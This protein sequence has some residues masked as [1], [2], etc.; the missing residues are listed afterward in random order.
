MKKTHLKILEELKQVAEQL[1]DN[2]IESF[3]NKLNKAERIFVAGEGRSGLMGKAFAMRLMHAGYD[4]FVKGETITPS[5]Q[6]ND[7]L[8]EI[9]GSGNSTSLLSAAQQVKKSGATLLLVTT[10]PDSELGHLADETIRVPAATKLRRPKEPVTIQ[11]MGNQFDQSVH[12]L[13]DAVVISLTQSRDDINHY[14]KEQH[15]NLD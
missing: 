8:V 10:A 11:P 15:E 9:S 1:D 14:M 13:L 7:V 5:I 2:Q 3:S 6:K 12:I 4:V